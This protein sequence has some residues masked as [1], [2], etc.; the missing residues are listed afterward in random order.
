MEAMPAA[1]SEADR[2]CTFLCYTHAWQVG[3]GLKI[4]LAPGKYRVT[5]EEKLNGVLFISLEGGYRIDASD[6]PSAA[7]RM[8]D[9]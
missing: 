4:S 1:N 5:S 7:A 2:F 9:E 3:T 8:E 6:L